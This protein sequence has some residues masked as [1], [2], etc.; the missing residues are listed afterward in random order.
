MEVGEGEW[1]N[2]NFKN[3]PSEDSLLSH[4]PPPSLHGT[5]LRG[6]D[7]EPFCVSALDSCCKLAVPKFSRE[8]GRVSN[9]NKSI[10]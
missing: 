5:V 1:E 9:F 7:L 8:P 2:L 4:P 6:P 3:V 10:N